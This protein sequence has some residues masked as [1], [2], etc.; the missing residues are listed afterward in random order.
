M[1]KTMKCNSSFLMRHSHLLSAVRATLP[2]YIY[3][4][5]YAAGARYYLGGRL[6]LNLHTSFTGGMYRTTF[7]LLVSVGIP[8]SLINGEVQPLAVLR[9]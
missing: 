9:Q 1:N 7:S 6:N 2:R 4:A 5:A 8:I 3:R